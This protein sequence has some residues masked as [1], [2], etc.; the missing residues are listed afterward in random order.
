M[1]HRVE[2]RDCMVGR[3]NTSVYIHNYSYPYS[4]DESSNR[5][6]EKE[7]YIGAERCMKE[8]RRITMEKAGR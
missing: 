7:R 6:K 1:K 8:E 5:Y 4:I 3:S 2:V